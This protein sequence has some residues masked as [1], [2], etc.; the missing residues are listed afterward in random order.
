MEEEDHSHVAARSWGRY[1]FQNV[2]CLTLGPL[3]ISE[4][5]VSRVRY[6]FFAAVC[7][8]Q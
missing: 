7:G 4:L 6:S 3:P 8:G 1:F 5:F 2:H